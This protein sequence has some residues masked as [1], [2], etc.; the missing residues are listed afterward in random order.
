[1]AFALAST[2]PAEGSPGLDFPNPKM[3]RRWHAADAR[4][5]GSLAVT[6]GRDAA[7][8]WRE[9]EDARRR[10]GTDIVT[11][12]RESLPQR[13]TSDVSPCRT[14]AHEPIKERETVTITTSFVTP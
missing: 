12:K 14:T 7:L 10:A 9:M 8:N 3:L 2:S 6:R 11:V 13:T 4:G 5:R 1:M